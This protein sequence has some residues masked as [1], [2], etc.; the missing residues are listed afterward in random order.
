MDKGCNQL[1][2]QAAK[3]A[4]DQAQASN[5]GRV[6]PYPGLEHRVPSSIKLSDLGSSHQDLPALQ[7]VSGGLHAAQA[8]HCCCYRSYLVVWPSPGWCFMYQGLHDTIH[9]VWLCSFCSLQ[10]SAASSG[11]VIGNLRQ[12]TKPVD[13]S[14]A[15]GMFSLTLVSGG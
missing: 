2:M 12:S 10:L 1:V 6:P 13:A 8:N 7:H 3:A 14:Q 4:G 5:G 9:F 15:L 11:C